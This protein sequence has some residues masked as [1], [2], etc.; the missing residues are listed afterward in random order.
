MWTCRQFQIRDEFRVGIYDGSGEFRLQLEGHLGAAESREVESCWRTAADT[1]AGRR[2][3]VDLSLVRSLDSTVEELLS[4]MRDSGAEFQGGPPGVEHITCGI[5][6][7][8]AD[9]PVAPA[10]SLHLSRF[11]MFVSCL[12]LRVK[13]WAR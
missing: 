1:I 8:A 6:K 7:G 10:N 9:P 12:M 13:A 11:A 4:R 2:F 3:T 5:K